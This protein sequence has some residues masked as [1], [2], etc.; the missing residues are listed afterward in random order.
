MTCTVQIKC[1][2][3]EARKRH[4]FVCV[5]FFFFFFLFFFLLLLFFFFFFFF[6][7]FFCFFLL[8]FFLL[9]IF[10]CFHRFAMYPYESAGVASLKKLVH[11]SGKHV[12]I[13]TTGKV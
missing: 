13:A 9:L 3:K 7:V 2:F 12:C 11:H 10:Q 8:F 6:V 5:F 1:L 4:T